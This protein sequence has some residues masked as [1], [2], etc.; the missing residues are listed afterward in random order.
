VKLEGARLVARV[1]HY[2]ALAVAATRQSG[3][4]AVP[5]VSAATSL[6]DAI[7][8]L[9][10]GQSAASSGAGHSAGARVVLDPAAERGEWPGDE[11]VTLISGPEGGFAPAEHD[12]LAAASFISLGLGPRVLRAETAP[13]IAV[14][15]LRA[16]TQS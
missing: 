13:V 7:A 8:K 5:A 12:A 1:E 6:G 16:A 3:R 15:L 10:R 14:A 4:A 2:Q 11:D 9:P